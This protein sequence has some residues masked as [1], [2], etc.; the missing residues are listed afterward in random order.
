MNSSLFRL[1]VRD[2]GKGA[3]LAVLASVLTP[4]LA[5]A[6]TGDFNALISLD[7]GAIAKTA[8]TVFIAY[9]L[10]NFLSDAE[11]RLGGVL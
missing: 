2:F 8:L 1:N 11:G 7:W 6:Q 3:V 4:I 9:V 5:A 10:K